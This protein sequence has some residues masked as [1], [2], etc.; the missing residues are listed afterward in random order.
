MDDGIDVACL[1]GGDAFAFTTLAVHLVDSSASVKGARKQGFQTWLPWVDSNVI[2]SLEHSIARCKGQYIFARSGFVS[3]GP[4]IGDFRIIN[5]G[6]SDLSIPTNDRRRI[7]IRV[8]SESGLKSI[9]VFNSANETFRR[10][11]FHGEREAEFE[12]DDWHSVN[13]CYF[14]EAVDQQGR[15][16]ISSRASTSI[17]ENSFF[18]CS[19]NLNT[20][21]RGKWYGQPEHLQNLRGF[22]DYSA[23]RDMT[24]DFRPLVADIGNA[25]KV[26]A[27]HYHP[28]HVSRYVS[29]IECDNL[30]YYPESQNTNPDKTDLPQQAVPNEYFESQVHYTVFTGRM[31]SS[32][33]KLI[34]ATIRIKQDFVSSRFDVFETPARRSTNLVSYTLADGT[35]TEKALGGKEGAGR[36]SAVLPLHGYVAMHRDILHGSCGFIPLTDNLGFTATGNATGNHHTLVGWLNHDRQFRKG[37]VVAV[38]YLSVT[39]CLDPQAGDGFIREVR[40]KLGVLGSVAYSVTPVR[41]SV[42]G[43]HFALQMEAQDYSVLADFS[44]AK[45]PLPL[46]VVVHGLN[47]NWD[48]GVVYVGDSRLLLPQWQANEYGQRFVKMVPRQEH[49]QLFHIAARQDGTAYVQVETELEAHRVF[50]GNLLVADVPSLKLTLL[51]TFPGGCSFEC[52][53][54]TDKAITASVQPAK[55]LDVLGNFTKKVQVAPGSS[56]TITTGK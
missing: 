1:L 25:G 35:V 9:R 47:P 31:D 55:G 56:V 52:H 46:P 34:E 14:L 51:D 53:N 12:C 20:M 17:Q 33:V 44:Q 21:P 28:L 11:L 39:S 42:K 19:D 50:I 38:R 29:L 36:V 7:H 18:R 32:L 26:P 23:S 45:L 15:R 24:W 41:G 49:D 54:P 16:A 10:F 2:E 27:I 8:S 40:D 48:A 30:E 3:E 6:T 4:L 37:E 22:E 5:F 43:K 13:Q